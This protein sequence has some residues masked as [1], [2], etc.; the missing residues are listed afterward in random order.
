M[1][2]SRFSF[3]EA[4]DDL[5]AAPFAATDFHQIGG[6]RN[7]GFMADPKTVWAGPETV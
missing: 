6:E 4:N 7:L 1:A 5:L 2:G 3:R